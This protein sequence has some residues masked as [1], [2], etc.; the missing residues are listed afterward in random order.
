MRKEISRKDLANLFSINQNTLGQYERGER[1]PSPEMVKRFSDF[2]GCSIDY[3][4]GTTDISVPTHELNQLFIND[5][6][7]PQHLQT[8][9]TALEKIYLKSQ[10]SNWEQDQEKAFT[11]ILE[12][13]KSMTVA[14]K[15]IPTS[16]LQLLLPVLVRVRQEIESDNE[17]SWE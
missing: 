6:L 12:I 1:K 17:K 2:F 13:L 7:D 11:E 10:S 9:I 3:L 5:Q 14:G 15:S 16:T 8:F 4:Y